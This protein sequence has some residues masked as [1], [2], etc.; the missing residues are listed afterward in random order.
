MNGEIKGAQSFYTLIFVNYDRL[1][2]KVL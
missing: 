1:F 2:C